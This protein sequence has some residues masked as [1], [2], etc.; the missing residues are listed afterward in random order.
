MS[1]TLRILSFFATLT[2]V[3]VFYSLI[4]RLE[5]LEERKN[6]LIYE[7]EQ[8]EPNRERIE[9]MKDFIAL[10]EKRFNPSSQIITGIVSMV[11]GFLL[12][13]AAIYTKRKEH[14]NLVVSTP[15][16]APSP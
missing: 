14:I 4:V 13:G 7:L 12:S 1:T 3:I 11:L 15:R 6:D 16:A 9:E 8:V 5:I 10:L 2:A